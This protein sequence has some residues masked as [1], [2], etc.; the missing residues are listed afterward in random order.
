MAELPP[1]PLA[2][3]R[4]DEYVACYSKRAGAANVARSMLG[5]L[6]LMTEITTPIAIFMF[7]GGIGTPFVL[8]AMLGVLS[9]LFLLAHYSTA[10]RHRSWKRRAGWLTA[11]AVV[12]GAIPLATLLSSRG[13]PDPR[14]WLN[15]LVGGGRIDALD[16]AS[17]AVAV[18]AAGT[19][20]AVLVAHGLRETRCRMPSLLLMRQA[21]E[22]MVCELVQSVDLIEAREL[23]DHKH[24]ARQLNV[25]G[26]L[27]LSVVHLY[28]RGRLVA[29]LDLTKKGRRAAKEK[30]RGRER[31]ISR[32]RDDFLKCCGNRA[33]HITKLTRLAAGLLTEHDDATE[34]VESRPSRFVL[35]GQVIGILVGVGGIAVAT[36]FLAQTVGPTMGVIVTGLGSGFI[37]TVIKPALAKVTKDADLSWLSKLIPSPKADADAKK[38]EKS[39]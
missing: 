16:P 29:E 38:D 9:A 25:V 21:R 30:F 15:G 20:I 36:S 17:T 19:L 23:A 7:L 26:E 32:I 24:R 27:L 35:V 39:S 13:I 37:M 31:Q 2:E 10:R 33:E 22:Q 14:V 3:F 8:L 28:S 4:F 34:I 11:A 5:I 6:A 18:A 12:S 1:Y